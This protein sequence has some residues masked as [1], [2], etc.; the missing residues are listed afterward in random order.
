MA[1]V[2]K[3]TDQAAQLLHYII[4]TTEIRHRAM[5][6]NMRLGSTLGPKLSVLSVPEAEVRQEIDILLLSIGGIKTTLPSPDGDREVTLTRWLG[7][8]PDAPEQHKWFG[9][10]G[11]AGAEVSIAP[12]VLLASVQA[13]NPVP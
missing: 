3:P 8:N 7:P 6:H 9:Q 10:G 12:E 5:L 2:I 11:G 4:E 1:E 13:Q